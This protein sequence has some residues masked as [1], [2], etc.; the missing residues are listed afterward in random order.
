MTYPKTWS[1]YVR[2]GSGGTDLDFYA[3]P[4][5]VPSDNV[6]Y[7]LRMSVVNREFSNEIKSYDS[8]VKQGD[9]KAGSV[10][11]SGVKGVRLDGF[12]KK[13][14]EGSMV[15]FPLRDKTLRVWTENK[16]YRGDFNNTVLKKLS[17]IP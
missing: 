17:F 6:N 13:D 7:A 2:Q 11:V 12:L 5:F 9:L 14:Q 16:E 1:A 3:H 8:Q 15:I 10:K 4:K